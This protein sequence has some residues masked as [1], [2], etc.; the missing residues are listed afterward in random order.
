MMS[1]IS[2]SPGSRLVSADAVVAC[3]PA[4]VVVSV[5]VAVVVVVV[6]DDC[7]LK[8]TKTKFRICHG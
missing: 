6:S 8:L 4:M 7:I 1:E 5:A 2:L 3:Y